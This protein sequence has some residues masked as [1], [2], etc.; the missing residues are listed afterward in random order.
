[1]ALSDGDDKLVKRA[2]KGD[3]RAFDLL[4]L[5][6]QGRVAQ[7]V[8]H[9]VNNAAEVEDVTQE[10]FIKAYRALPK[11]RGD[12]AFYTWLYR[13]AANAAKNHLV[14]LGRRPTTDLALDDSESYEVPGRLKDNESPDEVIMGQQLEAVISQAIDALPLEL[15]AAL[16][17]REFE[18]LSYDEIAE[19]LE[20]PI[21][22][23]RS[24]IFRAREAIDQKVASQMRGELG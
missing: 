1:L 10:A 23:V 9:Y 16:T 13:I 22:T 3:S 2:K 18:G 19:V 20:C 11:F 6:Y 4:V 7:L 24:R 5:K 14:A 15:K 8:S 12:S 17:L 21:G